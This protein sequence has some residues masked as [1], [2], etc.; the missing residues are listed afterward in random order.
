[1]EKVY[2]VIVNFNN[3]SDTVECLKSLLSS[4]YQNYQIFVV[5]N[6]PT[7][8]SV[9]NVSRWAAAEPTTSIAGPGELFTVTEENSFLENEYQ[10]RI[11]WVKANENKGFAA[12]NNIAL[13]YILSQ[14]DYQFV[15]ILNNDT[16]VPADSLEKLVTEFQQQP[17]QVGILGTTLLYY[18]NPS[19]IQGLGGAY[20]KWFATSS[21]LAEGMPVTDLHKFK[22]LA[23]DYPI[24]ASMCV[25]RKFLEEIGL[26][27]EEYF[28]YYE[29]LDWVRRG[30]LQGWQVRVSLESQVLHKEGASI[31]TG[32]PQKRSE[33]SD[34]YCLKNRLVFAKKYHKAYLPTVYV[35][36]GLTL[37]NRL[38]RRQFG[39]ARN[40]L[41]ILLKN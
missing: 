16:Y 31:G 8:E 30:Q 32:K 33:L 22:D 25:R 38:R 4:T 10:Q 2:I 6:S 20:N 29:E 28:L 27:N 18:H 36:F 21:H 41:K 26:M 40:I 9:D 12:A 23:I 37:L 11:V 13:G 7:R 14:Q 34:Y 15:W 39:M 24:G 19:L 1:M 5:D 35:G 3:W 17:A